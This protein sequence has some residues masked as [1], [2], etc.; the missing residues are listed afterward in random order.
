MKDFWNFL[1]W[2]GRS[3]S[4][5]NII[6]RKEAEGTISSTRWVFNVKCG[7][8]GQID[9]LKARLVA[10]GNKQ[11]DDFNETSALVFQLNILW[12]LIEMAV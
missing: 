1:A 7:L 10:R 4:F 9:C 11:L 5:L 3:S 12:I 6:L 2:K 8:D